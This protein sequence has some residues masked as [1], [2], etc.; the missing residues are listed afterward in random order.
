[1]A[2][3]NCPACRTKMSSVAKVCPKCGFTSEP[4]AEI[5]AEQVKLFQMRLFRE[6]MY[7]LRMLSYVA[8]TIAMIGAVPMLWDYIRGIELSEPLILMKHW[9][10]YAIAAGFFLYLVIRFL[11]TTARRR[12]YANIPKDTD[13]TSQVG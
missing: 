4:Q 6:R 9:G 3:I 11:M 13:S 12:Y 1:M 7:K 10:V 2:L 5:D 8:M